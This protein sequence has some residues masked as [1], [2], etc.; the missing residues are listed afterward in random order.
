MRILVIRWIIVFNVEEMDGI[1]KTN[2]KVLF[3]FIWGLW[4][5]MV[6]WS[7]RLGWGQLFCVFILLLWEYVLLIWHLFV[8][9]EMCLLVVEVEAGMSSSV[10]CGVGL[11]AVWVGWGKHWYTE[12]GTK[13]FKVRLYWKY[14]D[15]GMQVLYRTASLKMRQ[16]QK[17]MNNS[18]ICTHCLCHVLKPVPSI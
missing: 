7:S 11:V 3:I 10:L 18:L 14:F 12:L 8:G 9:R 5:K 4:F 15:L 17:Q 1:H 16:C 2:E 6:E 13:Y